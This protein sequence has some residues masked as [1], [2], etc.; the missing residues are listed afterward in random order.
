M[1]KLT[2]GG[3]LT[4]RNAAGERKYMRLS[5]ITKT[6][7]TKVCHH[8]SNLES[9]LKTN[10]RLAPDTVAWLNSI[11]VWLHDK[12]AG[13]GLIEDRQ[14]FELDAYIKSYVDSR[15]DLKER[16][17]IKFKATRRY[18]VEHFGGDTKIHEITSGHGNEFREWL[19][20]RGLKENTIRKHI[21]I[22]SQIFKRAFDK[23]QITENPFYGQKTTTIPNTDRD[24]IVTLDE[25]EKMLTA[26]DDDPYWKGIIAFC[27][28]GGVRFPSELA[29]LE[30]SHIERD[31][32]RIKIHSP[33]TEHHEG[34]SWRYIPLFPELVRPVD[35]LWDAAPE[36]QRFV[37]S[38]NDPEKFMK[39]NAKKPFDQIR[40]KA[41]VKLWKRP[42]QN[43]RI[44]RENELVATG[45]PIHVAAS[46]VGN[47]PLVAMKHYLKVTDSDFD[48][49]SSTP[50]P[51]EKTSSAR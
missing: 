18:L 40:K 46:W 33:K 7:Q 30:W 45:C 25:Y 43:M 14:K 32:N 5:A 48:R 42:F 37:F 41:K 2:K 13:A 36:R 31:E 44:S 34:K 23:K 47:S 6:D 24:Y 51:R 3:R 19:S 27:R 39:W 26:C 15:K 9:S 35:E 21:Q 50:T 12:L 4:F 8:V 28:I 29:N 49:F 10:E 22:A 17:L 20:A 11:A 1:A 16:T 38:D